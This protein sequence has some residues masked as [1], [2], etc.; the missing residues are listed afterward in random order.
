MGRGQGLALFPDVRLHVAITP[1][2]VLSV[3][4][5]EE[6]APRDLAP[7]YPLEPPQY[8]LR[9]RRFCVLSI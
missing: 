9:T 4:V 7:T 3:E 1:A 6:A 2:A 5:R 8:R